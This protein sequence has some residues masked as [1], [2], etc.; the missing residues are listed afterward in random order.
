MIEITVTLQ[1]KTPLN[2]GSGTQQGTL[3]QRAM[4]KTRDGWPYVPAS[5]FKGRL[6]HAVEQ[7]AQTLGLPQPIAITH[8]DRYQRQAD[9]VAE[10]FGSPWLPGCLRFADLSLTGPP[11]VIALRETL[12]QEYRPPRTTQRTGISLNRRRK[13]AEDNFLYSTELLWP[14]AILQFSGSLY[15]KITMKQAGL[16]VAGV[17]LLPALGRGKSGGLGWVTGSAV[18]STSSGETWTETMLLTALK[19]GE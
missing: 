4:L 7:V 8:R 2:I 13:V 19:E 14:G 10:I 3:A 9:I 11:T 15:G 12:K 18:V 16:I 5:A 1:F 17:K 6:R